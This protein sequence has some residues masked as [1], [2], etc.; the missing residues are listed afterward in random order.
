MLV[1]YTNSCPK[2]LLDQLI[3]GHSIAKEDQPFDLYLDESYTVYG[4]ILIG[5]IM[6]YY[7]ATNIDPIILSKYPS[8]LFEIL[9]GKLS[10]YW[11]CSSTYTETPRSIFAFPKWANDP[12][13]ELKL[14]NKN[15][16]ELDLL[17]VYKELMDMEFYDLKISGLARRIDHE[18]LGCLHCETKW[19]S[20]GIEAQV[21]C[22]GCGIVMHNPRYRPITQEPPEYGS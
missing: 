3:T 14:R 9:D 8:P 22:P 7:L 2:T 17:K 4:M 1:K 12:N 18:Y 10:K 6:W 13:F 21:R 16:Q 15:K 20:I 5:D 11:I 19:H